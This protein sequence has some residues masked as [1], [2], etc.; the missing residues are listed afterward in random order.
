MHV[1]PLVLHHLAQQH[2]NLAPRQGRQNLSQ[3]LHAR[4]DRVDCRPLAPPET[5]PE[6]SF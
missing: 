5:V 1:D 2:L 4:A 6:E 3:L